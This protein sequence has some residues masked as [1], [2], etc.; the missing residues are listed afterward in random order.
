VHGKH[1]CNHD[2]NACYACDEFDGCTYDENLIGF[3]RET[4]LN[5][6]Y[7]RWYDPNTSY[8]AGNPLSKTDP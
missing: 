2:A 8:V 5:H 3:D 4:N 7:H 6:N 1:V